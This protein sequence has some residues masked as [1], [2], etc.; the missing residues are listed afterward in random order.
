MDRQTSNPERHKTVPQQ[1]DKRGGAAPKKKKK[2]IVRNI[3]LILLV[4]LVGGLGA[5]YFISTMQAEYVI[6]YQ[7]YTATTGTISNSLSFSGTL[8]AVNDKT[9]TAESDADVRNIYVSEGDTVKEGDHIMRLSNGQLIEAEFDGKVNSI[10]VDEGDQVIAG[11]TLCQIVDFEHQ[12]VNIRVDEYDIGDVHVGDACR[13][14]TTATE[15]TFDS[16]ISSINYVSA[17]TGN[18]AYYTAVAYADVTD[19]VYPGMQVTVTIPKEEAKDVV[20]LKADAIS[21]DDS[22]KAF[23]YTMDENGVITQTYI[24]TGVSNGNYVEI[25]DGLK[26]GDT[27]YAVVENETDAVTNMFAGLFGGQRVMGG[28]GMGGG[29]N[30]E[31]GDFDRGNF[32]RGNMP[33]RQQSD[34][35][36]AGGNNG[37]GGR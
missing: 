4:I 23:V 30:F 29:R 10:S 31:R 11:D 27:V 6:N 24:T 2:H 5:W 15:Q 3:L 21:F 1:T 26:S 18:V 34:R 32:D 14:T 12:K 19:G 8:Q 36:S 9:Y 17:S 33:E 20:I 16:V 28:G 35:N 25:K 7:P 13:I 37:G 22:N